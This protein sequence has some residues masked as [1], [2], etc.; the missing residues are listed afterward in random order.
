M[1]S[2]REKPDE[3]TAEQLLT[4]GD[5][6]WNTGIKVWKVDRL[7]SAIKMIMPDSYASLVGLRAEMGTPS[8]E[9]MLD[10]WYENIEPASFEVAVSERLEGQLVYVADYRWE[11][12]GSWEVFYKLAK[13]DDRGNAVV[14]GLPGQVVELVDS[15]DC[16]V[17][18]R[19]QQ[20]AI[21][22]IKNAVIV[23]SDEKLLVCRR[24]LVSEVKGLFSGR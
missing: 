6:V 7:L 3:T 19:Q 22:G 13:K 5:F 23:Q 9:K 16:L 17:I 18:P 21:I 10:A 20:V 12:M 14:N 4:S 15:D 2:F 1:R 24:D 11:D 8:Y